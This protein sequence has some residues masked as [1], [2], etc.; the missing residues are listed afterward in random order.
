MR[1][2]TTETGII[3]EHETSARRP[4]KILLDFDCKEP[5]SVDS[6]ETCADAIREDKADCSLIVHL[7]LKSKDSIE[8]IQKE[9]KRIGREGVLNTLALTRRDFDLFLLL[10]RVKDELRKK[11]RSK[12]EVEKLER[13]VK[14]LWRRL[15]REVERIVKNLFDNGYI[16]SIYDLHDKDPQ[17]LLSL[18]L[19]GGD[20][21]TAYHEYVKFFFPLESNVPIMDITR[22]KER[23]K[24]KQ[25]ANG[26]WKINL[27]AFLHSVL[28][29]LTEGKRKKTVISR[30]FMIV[31]E[32]DLLKWLEFL[33]SLSTV[34]PAGD[35]WLLRSFADLNKE[36]EQKRVKDPKGMNKQDKYGGTLANFLAG[37]DY[38]QLKV[39]LEEVKKK[40]KEN[41]SFAEGDLL[42]LI[43]NLMVYHAI[44]VKGYEQLQTVIHEAT[45]EMKKSRSELDTANDD[46]KGTRENL[47]QLNQE[48][49]KLASGG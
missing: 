8:R 15:Y 27:P 26:D 6:I 37:F 34:H 21:S 28:V 10:N 7:G 41:A 47:K 1:L 36:L 23:I 11:D 5:M 14:N 40:F 33:A 4:V 22:A 29:D 12:L 45:Q 17:I 20:E 46:I 43:R 13:E 9:E 48:L 2:T 38:D 24:E 19:T 18:S 39:K 25:L 42:N 30:R 49:D 35:Y 16:V 44:Y 31:D 3:W 32:V